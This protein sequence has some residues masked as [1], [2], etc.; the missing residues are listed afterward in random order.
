[1]L[2]KNSFSTPRFPSLISIN[3]LI[4][5]YYLFG[6]KKL[7]DFCFFG[8]RVLGVNLRTPFTGAAEALGRCGSGGDA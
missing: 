8:L 7:L 6:L 1:M 2:E 4:L 5:F 3:H